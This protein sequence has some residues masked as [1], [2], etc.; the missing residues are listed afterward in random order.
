[1][2]ASLRYVRQG[3]A[4]CVLALVAGCAKPDAEPV[5][6]NQ[7]VT[8]RVARVEVRESERTQAVAGTVR[9]RDHA[10]VAAKLMGTVARVSVVVGQTV[11][12]GDEL[13]VLEADEVAARLAQA[14]AV[15]A[16]VRREQARETALRDQGVS[17]PETVRA[18]EDRR[19]AAEAAVGEA[20]TLETYTRV[21]APF[22]GVVTRQLIREGDLAM[23]G[24]PLVA[25][26]GTGGLTVELEVPGGLPVPAVGAK[27]T[28]AHPGGA[29]A[30]G[31][32]TEISAAVD[33]LTRTRFA[34]LA[35]EPAASGF[36]S[37]DFVRVNWPAGQGRELV[38]PAE[39]VR[40][41]GQ[42]ERVFV[43][44][45]GRVRMRLVKSAGRLADGAVRI[46]SGLE[47][48]ELV[49]LDAPA[50]IVDGQRAEV[51]R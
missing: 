49:V 35:L 2:H 30:Q 15:L 19:R 40:S 26:E 7:A 42:L 34:E 21:T 44:D 47:A 48:D 12:A 38:V 20:R 5:A 1:M 41:F 32:L 8:V 14:E 9:A 39:A 4:I 51:S 10:I 24:T 16:G 45:E 33:P 25:I 46:N 22:G 17:A 50:G 6:E 36:G 23:P 13:A 29:N 11:A 31:V 28:V 37:G 3:A 43:W 18:L 27:L